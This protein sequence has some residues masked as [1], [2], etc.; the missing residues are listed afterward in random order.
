MILPKSLELL[1]SGARGV[2]TVVEV[3]D[4]ISEEPLSAL[5]PLVL[6]EFLFEHPE[7]RLTE[8]DRETAAATIAYVLAYD[9]AYS[10]PT[11]VLEIADACA[12]DF[13]ALF[14]S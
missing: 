6:N 12:N 4:A 5:I 10:M 11:K 13:V 7:A 14:P 8:I 1:H 3:Q 9:L 2:F